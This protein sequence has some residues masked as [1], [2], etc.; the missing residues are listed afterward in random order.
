MADSGG[1]G[2]EEGCSLAPVKKLINMKRFYA[3][4]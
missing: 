3:N 2:E 1:K 4:Y